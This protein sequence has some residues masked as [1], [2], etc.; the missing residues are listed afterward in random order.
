MN[1]NRARSQSK[2]CKFCKW[3]FR[4]PDEQLYRVSCFACES[5]QEEEE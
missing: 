5:K 3:R 2:P 1:P 4:C